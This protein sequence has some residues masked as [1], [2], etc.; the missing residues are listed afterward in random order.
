MLS[1]ILP[2]Y[3]PPKEW[4]LNVLQSFKLIES[5]LDSTE[6]EII[7]VNDGTPNMS[8]QK[9]EHFLKENIP[10]FNF[11]HNHTNMGKGHAIRTGINISLGEYIIYTDIDFPYTIES[12]IEIYN[13]LKSD[14]D[15]AIGIKDNQYYEKVPTLRKLISKSLRFIIGIFLRLPITDTQCGLKGMK[16]DIKPIFLNTTISRYLFDLEFV[17]SCFRNKPKLNVVAVP[18]TLN[19]NIVFRKMNPKILIQELGNFFMILIRK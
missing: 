17:R 19:D 12:I 1:I 4:E 7:I 5:K 9:E 10:N 18:V 13:T 2:C 14:V 11:I 3:N 15:V 8:F 6:I 16:S